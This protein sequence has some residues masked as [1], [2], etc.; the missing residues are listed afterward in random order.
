VEGSSLRQV[1]PALLRGR[2]GRGSRRRRSSC[3]CCCCLSF[4][5][6]PQHELGA[7]AG[8][9]QSP[10]GVGASLGDRRVAR[11]APGSVG[12]V[13]GG[14]GLQQERDA[15]HGVGLGGREERGTARDGV[16]VGGCVLRGRGRRGEE[17]RGERRGI[18]GCRGGEDDRNVFWQSLLLP[19]L[20]LC[21]FH[22]LDAI[23]CLTSSST[24]AME[25]GN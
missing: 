12:G 4:G 23:F 18:A 3:C 20:F 7:D 8:L 11:A 16:L 1:R 17:G 21:F 24:S 10:G 9:Q 5:D 25:I 14:P 6:G 15:L 19:W 2:Q 22:S 13:P